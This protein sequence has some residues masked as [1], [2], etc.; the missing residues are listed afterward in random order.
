MKQISFTDVYW[1][2]S[3]R[4]EGERKKK[5]ELPQVRRDSPGFC[6]PPAGQGFG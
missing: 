5:Q 3:S 2:K 6:N 1:R 4:N